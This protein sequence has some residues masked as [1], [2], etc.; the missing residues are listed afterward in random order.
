MSR[1]HLDGLPWGGDLPEA[2]QKF[3]SPHCLWA[4]LDPKE[5]SRGNGGRRWCER[6]LR[7]RVKEPDT[8]ALELCWALPRAICCANIVHAL[9]ACYGGHSFLFCLSPF[10]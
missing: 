3:F 8:L 1:R 2:A 5:V 10:N 4:K 7:R 9:Y 6:R